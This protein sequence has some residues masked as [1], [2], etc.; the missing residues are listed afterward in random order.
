MYSVTKRVKSVKQ[1]RGGYL[2]K[3]LFNKTIINDG[4]ELKDNENIH[5]SLIGTAVDYLTRFMMG[6]PKEEA[7]N[8]SLAGAK[9][10]DEH[11]ERIVGRRGFSTFW[12]T[13]LLKQIKGLDS[14][15]IEAAC[16]LVG[17]DVCMRAGVGYYKPVQDIKPNSET[18]HNVRVMVERCIHFW[19]LH[20][21]ILKDGIVFP[22]AY[23]DIIS[24]GD[25]DF[26]TRDTLWDFKVLKGDIT[27]INTLQLLVYYIMGTHSIHDEFKSVEKIGIYN[28]RK[29]EIYLLNVS[30]ITC[31]LINQVSQEVI[32]YDK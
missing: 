25:A 10:H 19:D 22:G 26:L 32:G 1:P 27:S 13:F 7:F 23:T 3:K 17:F 30:S 21:P 18:I 20:G 5:G 2:N 29:N 11:Y 8:I 14:H 6:T 24:S 9:I 4:E 16:K 31:E 15:S 12:S 28:P